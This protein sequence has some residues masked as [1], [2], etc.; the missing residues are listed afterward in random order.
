MVRDGGVG[1][2]VPSSCSCSRGYY[3]SCFCGSVQRPPRKWFLDAYDNIENLSLGLAKEN[4]LNGSLITRTTD[5]EVRSAVRRARDRGADRLGDSVGAHANRRWRCGGLAPHPY[6]RSMNSHFLAVA[7]IVARA[8]ET[9][10]PAGFC[11]RLGFALI[12][13]DVRL[14]SAVRPT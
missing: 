2:L 12:F 10:A 8:P 14:F 5:D 4:Q 3:P 7:A 13:A 6:M 11:N 9:L 1:R